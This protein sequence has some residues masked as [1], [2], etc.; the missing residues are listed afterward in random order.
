MKT[1]AKAASP[2]AISLAYDGDH[3]DGEVYPFLLTR[4]D[5]VI[6]VIRGGMVVVM[7]CTR[8]AQH[9]AM[10]HLLDDE[11]SC[12]CMAIFTPQVPWIR[13]RAV[14]MFSHTRDT[15]ECVNLG[16]ES[17]GSIFILVSQGHLERGSYANFGKIALR[18]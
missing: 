10:N 11:L 18:G 3:N 8:K 5:S 15:S 16:D 17:R 1:A 13:V 9:L 12:E 6:D 4:V 14:P 7:V 2:L